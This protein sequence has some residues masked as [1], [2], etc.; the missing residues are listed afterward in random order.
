M[1]RAMRTSWRHG[2]G[3]PKNRIS[4]RVAGSAF[5]A[6][7]AGGSSRKSRWLPKISARYY[8]AAAA[9]DTRRSG[10]DRTRTV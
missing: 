4:C 5:P 6:D 3:H 1:M 7:R 8:Q 2:G 10:P 9:S